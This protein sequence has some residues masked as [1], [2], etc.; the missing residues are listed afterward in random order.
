M[1]KNEI[2]PRNPGEKSTGNDVLKV[3]AAFLLFASCA[4]IYYFGEL[5]E[6]AGW[7]SLKSISF[8]FGVHD[9][10]RLLFLA[11][12]MYAGYYFGVR[13]AIIII[14]LAIGAFLPRAL[15][16][17]PYPDPLLRTALFSITAG[18][19]GYF[20]AVTSAGYRK[21]RHKDSQHTDAE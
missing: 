10:H 6:F 1:S 16:I 12:I 19:V 21:S 3:Y 11:P 4:L 20:F 2:D 9:I 15:F 7:E 13:A 5:I 8:F 17:S 18:V 14:I